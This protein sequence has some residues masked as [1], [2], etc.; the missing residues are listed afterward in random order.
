MASLQN[1]PETLIP[2]G[3]QARRESRLDEARQIFSESVRLSR[4]AANPTALAASLAGLGQIERDL[5]NNLVA[6]Q[7]YR[8]AAQI[9]R[10]GADRLGFAHTIRHLADILR[11]EQSYEEAASCY[12]EAL[13]T[14]R[15]HHST[16]PLDLANAI[17]GF[18]L[19]KEN[20]GAREEARSS[21]QEARRLYES[22]EVRAG[23]NECDARIAE[24]SSQ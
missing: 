20:T 6:L 22:V 8:E 1:T 17:R 3:Y 14:Y 15:D 9:L 13:R 18:A 2:L 11:H 21:W 23:V 7:C 4:E 10:G 12:E 5:K 16:T 19:L 24:L